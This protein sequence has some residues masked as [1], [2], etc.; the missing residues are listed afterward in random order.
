MILSVDGS[1]ESWISAG[2]VDLTLVDT[3]SGGFQMIHEW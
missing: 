3:E 1:D 2:E